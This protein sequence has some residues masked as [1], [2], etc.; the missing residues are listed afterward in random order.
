MLL[1]LAAADDDDDVVGKRDLE[2]V[3]TYIK[4]DGS[5]SELLIPFNLAIQHKRERSFFI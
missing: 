1:L 2:V 3:R 4:A 5:S